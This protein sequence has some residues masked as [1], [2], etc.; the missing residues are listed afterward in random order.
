MQE[1][2]GHGVDLKTVN[3]EDFDQEKPISPAVQT[4]QK[5]QRAELVVGIRIDTVPTA[6]VDRLAEEGKF[7]PLTIDKSGQLR[8]VLPDGAKVESNEQQVMHEIRG[9]LE[10]IRD[11]LMEM[12]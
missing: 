9:L 5:P 11:L 10:E 6:E 1:V 3:R 2:G 8:V 7:Y 12:A 4:K